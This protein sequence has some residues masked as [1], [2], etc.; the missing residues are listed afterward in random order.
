M[1]LCLF[2]GGLLCFTLSNSFPSR[3]SNILSIL[4]GIWAIKSI[5]PILLTEIQRS[6][7][8]TSTSKKV[9]DTGIYQNYVLGLLN[10]HFWT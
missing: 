7:T 4:I 3:G 6:W 5:V 9:A 8:T 2:I 1:Y 10:E